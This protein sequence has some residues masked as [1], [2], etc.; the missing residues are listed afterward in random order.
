[1]GEQSWSP[2]LHSLLSCPTAGT[3]TLS[4][5]PALNN[6]LILHTDNMKTCHCVRRRAAWKDSQGSSTSCSVDLFCICTSRMKEKKYHLLKAQLCFPA[7]GTTHQVKRYCECILTTYSMQRVFTLAFL[8]SCREPFQ[9][10]SNLYLFETCHWWRAIR[11]LY[12]I[13]SYI[14]ILLTTY[15]TPTWSRSTLWKQ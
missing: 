11:F 10:N 3:K 5:L 14:Y 13:C 15:L 8:C 7:L 6:H 2:D 12:F 9:D 4:M 1:M